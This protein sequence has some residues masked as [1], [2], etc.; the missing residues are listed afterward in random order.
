M[1]TCY[2]ELDT[3][4][5]TAEWDETGADYSEKGHKQIREAVELEWTRLWDSSRQQ[6]KLKRG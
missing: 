1:E 6:R 4:L 2:P 5:A 3:A